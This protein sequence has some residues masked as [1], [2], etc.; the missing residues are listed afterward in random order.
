MAASLPPAQAPAA[1]IMIDP[2]YPAI[3][4]DSPARTLWLSGCPALTIGSAAF[5]KRKDDGNLVCDGTQAGLQDAVLRAAAQGTAQTAAP[6]RSVLLVPTDSPHA[7]V[8][9]LGVM[10][11]DK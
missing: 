6:Q 10:M 1:T 2:W 8:D 7:M 11:M 5:N 3:P 9:D 4:R